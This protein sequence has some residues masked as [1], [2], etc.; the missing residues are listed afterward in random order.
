MESIFFREGRSA[1]LDGFQTNCPYRV[2]TRFYFEWLRGWYSV[3]GQ[4]LAA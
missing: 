4:A 1:A 3:Y 2:N